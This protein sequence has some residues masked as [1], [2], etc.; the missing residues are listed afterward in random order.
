MSEPKYVTQDEFTEKKAIDQTLLITDLS[1]QLEEGRKRIDTLEAANRDW[2]S[3]LAR[4]EGAK[5]ALKELLSEFLLK[6]RP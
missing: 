6:S 1:H 3:R 2:A 5:E 4:A